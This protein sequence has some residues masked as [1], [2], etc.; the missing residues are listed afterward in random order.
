[1]RI[2]VVGATGAV[3]REMIEELAES[4]LTSDVKVELFASPRSEGETIAYRGETL[5]VNAYSLEKVKG[6]DYILMSAG[7]TF[8][9]AHSPAISSQD[10]VVIDNSSA[11]RMDPKIPLIIPEVN[12]DVL[13]GFTQGIIANP[14]CSTI[15]MLVAIN[16]LKLK[17]GLKMIVV[18]TYQSVS[19]SGQKGIKELS[20]QLQDYLKFEKP[21]HVL[22]PQPIA[23]N[24]LSAIGPFEDGQNCEEELKMVNETH[25]ILG[26]PGLPVLATSAR[27]PVFACHSEAINVQLGREADLEEVKQAF[28]QAPGLIYNETTSQSELPS[29]FHCTGKKEVFVARLRTLFGEPRSEWFQFWNVADNLK[30]G[31]ATNAV[32]ILEHLLKNKSS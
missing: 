15:Q 30:K 20:D 24:V 10:S 9:K 26:L 1:M 16:P 28:K 27:V 21:N 4:S 25:K 11:F 23:S 7:G 14:N 5:K 2:G 12:G 31:A 29:P 22:Y 18:A 19:G 13:Q 6:C 32:Q 8:S 17:F 3:G